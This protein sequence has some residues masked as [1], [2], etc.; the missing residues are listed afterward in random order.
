MALPHHYTSQHSNTVYALLY[1]G[2]IDE[3]GAVL[4][5]LAALAPRSHQTWQ[6]RLALAANRGEWQAADSMAAMVLAW[7]S[8]PSLRWYVISHQSA[9]LRG[10]MGRLDG[11]L[12]DLQRI[13]DV[14]SMVPPEFAPFL[15]KTGL[16]QVRLLAEVRGDTAAASRLLDRLVQQYPVDPMPAM[17]RPLTDLAHAAAVLGRP[18]EAER[19]LAAAAAQHPPNAVRKVIEYELA[20]A[21]LLLRTSRTREAAE[22][23]RIAAAQNAC[24]RCVA[25]PLARAFEELG[26]PDSAAAQYRTFAESS[27]AR[28]LE[29]DALYRAAAR[30]RLAELLEA[31]GD[32]AGATRHYAAFIELWRNADPAL[33]PRVRVAERRLAALA[34]RD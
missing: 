1:M 12:S 3:A 31:R 29:G 6:W 22:V 4:D 17:D 33:Q 16:R 23:L 30:F 27:F 26:Q 18:A 14:G 5:T 21:E 11:A 9:S 28:D 13:L 10:T 24:A 7:D 25:V 2:R 34:G 19:W 32:G 20:R 15:L 8:V